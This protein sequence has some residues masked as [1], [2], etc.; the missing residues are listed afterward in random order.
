MGVDDDKLF[1]Q[2][3]API[4]RERAV[5][6]LAE[7]REVFVEYVTAVGPRSADEKLAA[8]RD[9]QP[10][11]H[12]AA[13]VITAQMY[14][15]AD[16]VM[17]ALAVHLASAAAAL[18]ICP[19]LDLTLGPLDANLLGLVVHLDQVHLTLVADDTQGI[20]GEALLPSLQRRHSP[21]LIR[22]RRSAFMASRR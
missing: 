2:L 15:V 8:V 5:A 7:L 20:L 12:P 4:E 9:A 22:A 16:A 13:A 18:T 14:V 19:V 21:E 6:I 10:E 17:A 1:G 3:E 11:L